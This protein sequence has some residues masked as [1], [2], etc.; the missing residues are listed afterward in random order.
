M[1]SPSKLVKFLSKNQAIFSIFRTRSFMHLWPLLRLNF[2]NKWKLTFFDIFPFKDSCLVSLSQ[3]VFFFVTETAYTL[4]V[5]RLSRMDAFLEHTLFILVILYLLLFLKAFPRLVD[6]WW[7]SQVV[8]KF[9]FN[10]NYLL[11][12]ILKSWNWYLSRG[13]NKQNL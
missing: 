4:C 10:S 5:P 12:L 1:V 7:S 2:L 11:F 3:N 9:K 6:I 13:K 8:L